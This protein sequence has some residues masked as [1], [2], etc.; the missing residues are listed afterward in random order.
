M[1][2]RKKVI[3]GLL[4]IALVVTPLAC[5]LGFKKGGRVNVLL[6]G[7]PGGNYPGSNLSDSLIV[8]SLDPHRQDLIVVSVPRDIWID[9]FKTKINALYAL[10]GLGP[11]KTETSQILG[12]QEI[13]FGVVADFEGFKKVINLVGGLEIEVENSFDDS[14]YPFPGKE[15]DDCGG[16]PDYRCRYEHL[17]FERGLTQMDGELTLKFARSRFATDSAE[18]TDFA[19]S[20][21]Q[22]KIVAALKEKFFSERLFLKPIIVWGFLEIFQE[23]IVTDL[24]F[25]D[26]F[27]LLKLFFGADWEEP[28][29]FTLDWGKE[30]QGGLLVN[31][32]AEEYGS[33]VLVPR[34]GDWQEV[35]KK[36]K[37][38]L[39]SEN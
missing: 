23:H 34:S 19:R 36:F 28:R 25:K 8:F 37:N 4:V 9:S 17:R 13:D 11:V 1:S 24:N 12:L 26:V 33:W 30:N 31:P 21:R 27:S 10:G 14:H 15:D 16:D 22:Q 7:V 35:Q 18:G 38:F 20:K 2:S 3:L 5:H 6:L 39:N 29:I 32:P